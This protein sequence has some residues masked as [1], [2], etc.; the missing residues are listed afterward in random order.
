MKLVD[1]LIENIESKHG[2]MNLKEDVYYLFLPDGLFTLYYDEDEKTIKV[3][4]EF[5]P[6]EKTYVYYTDARLSELMEDK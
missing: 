4:V 6:E 3:N 5:L 2:K 1:R